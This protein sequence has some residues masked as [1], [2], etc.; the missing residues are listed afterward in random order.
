MS[1]EL[2]PPPVGQCPEP[3]SERPVTPQLPSPAWHGGGQA[4]CPGA[5]VCLCR[6]VGLQLLAP[7]WKGP[8]AP[9]LSRG[10]EPHPQ[11]RGIRPS[12]LWCALVE[13]CIR[14]CA[15]Q[16]HTGA[17]GS[18][19]RTQVPGYGF[20]IESKSPRRLLGGL[21]GGQ[22]TPPGG[23]GPPASYLS[24]AS[25]PPWAL[26]PRLPAPLRCWVRALSLWVGFPRRR[27]WGFRGWQWGVGSGW[28]QGCVTLHVTNPHWGDFLICHFRRFHWVMLKG[29]ARS[30]R[31]VPAAGVT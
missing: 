9:A 3:D 8:W 15:S 29:S 11:G 27:R 2:R 22:P 12:R 10:Q 21:G 23:Q 1:L 18:E 16:S 7:G 5:A 26:G 19:Q 14:C 31:A 28:L 25:V 6:V 17:P 13:G 30:T 24:A 4:C 20:K